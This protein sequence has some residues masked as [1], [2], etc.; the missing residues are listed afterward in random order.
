MK[1]QKVCDAIKYFSN[2][3]ISGG[4]IPVLK[5][6]NTMLNGVIVE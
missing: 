5:I 3:D 4:I 1:K 6:D 2:S